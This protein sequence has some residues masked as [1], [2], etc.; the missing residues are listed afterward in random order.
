MRELSEAE[1]AEEEKEDNRNTEQLDPLFLDTIQ[2]EMRGDTLERLLQG[3]NPIAQN[4]SNPFLPFTHPSNNSNALNALSN[5]AT[6]T[7]QQQENPF[8]LNLP[9]ALTH[10]M[11]QGPSQD[12]DNASFFASLPPEL[13]EEVLMSSD[14]AFLGTLPPEI[15]SEFPSLRG[16]AALARS[17]NNP[18]LLS[19]GD[20]PS[21]SESEMWPKPKKQAKKDKRG[22]AIGKQKDLL[23]KNPQQAKSLIVEEK[24][25][26]NLVGFMYV[27]SQV[28][29]FL[30]FLSLIYRFI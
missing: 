5:A 26:E 16:H 1:G 24:V 23:M 9:V 8:N 29:I 21:S 2:N 19:Q 10:S 18:L 17:L 4:N 20:S 6:Q 11:G 3:N 13:R 22:P 7:Q 12:M 30:L 28:I 25:L 14:P 15:L 27:D